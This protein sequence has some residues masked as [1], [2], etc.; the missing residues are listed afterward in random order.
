[1]EDLVADK[2]LHAACR[3]IFRVGK[4]VGLAGAS[5]GKPLHLYQHQ[6]QAIRTARSGA[7]YVL[8][9]GTGSGKSLTYIIP[10]VDR[11]LREPQDKGIKAIVIYPMNALA[12]SQAGELE[13][14]L[15]NGFPDNV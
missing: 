8:T 5:T 11:V 6:A 10:I 4:G 2:T 13:K 12:N 7:N 14:F 3:D 1:I 15:K 9:T